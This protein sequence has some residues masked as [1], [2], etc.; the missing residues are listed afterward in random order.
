MNAEAIARSMLER[1]HEARQLCEAMGW[2][3]EEKMRVPREL[4]A[5]V[6]RKHGIG[7]VDAVLLLHRNE[8]KVIN[9]FLGACLVAAA[10]ETVEKGVRSA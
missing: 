10:V 6:M 3:Y 2:N 7:A 4:V 9:D 1:R 5:A 8:G